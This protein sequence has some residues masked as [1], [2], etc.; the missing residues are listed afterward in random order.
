[1]IFTTQ[2]PIEQLNVGRDNYG[3][4]IYSETT[5]DAIL[6]D[7]GTEAIKALNFIEKN[8]LNLLY[9]INTHNHWD[10]VNENPRVKKACGCKTISSKSD[11]EGIPGGVDIFVEDGEVLMLSEIR[12]EFLITPGHTPGSVCLIVDDKALITGDT[13]FIGDCGRT[14]FPGGSDELMFQTLQRLKALPDELI[15]YPGHHYGP[16]PFDTLGNLKMTNITLL[17]STQKEFMMIP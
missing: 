7:P 6:V 15:V 16:K 12:I 14:D 8:K 3:Y 1:M 11:A 4:L 2:M 9:I 13:L 17:A 10:H 5:R